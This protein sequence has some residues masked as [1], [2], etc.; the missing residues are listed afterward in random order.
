MRVPLPPP[1]EGRVLPELCGGEFVGGGNIAPPLADATAIDHGGRA[2]KSRKRRAWWRQT[3]AS[4]TERVSWRRAELGDGMLP[5]LAFDCGKWDGCLCRTILTGERR[6]GSEPRRSGGSSLAAVEG[7]RSGGRG[8]RRCL[9]EE[10]T[11]N[12]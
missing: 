10:I 5:I 6:P 9:G 12:Y 2:D 8:V 11:R 7:G 4:G 1:E 3:D